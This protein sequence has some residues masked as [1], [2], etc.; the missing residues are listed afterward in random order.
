MG[1][2]AVLI[3]EQR[4]ECLLR[5]SFVIGRHWSCDLQLDHKRMPLRWIEIRWDGTSWRWRALS[6]ADET[7]G[8]G[9]VELGEWRRLGDGDADRAQIALGSAFRVHLLD[10]SPPSSHL[11]NVKTGEIIDAHLDDWLEWVDERPFA[12]GWDSEMEPEALQDGA[13]MVR[14]GQVWR[15]HLAIVSV[16]TE[17]GAFDLSRP[18]L[19]LDL[20]FNPIRATFTLGS[21]Q[22]ILEGNGARLVAAYA[23]VRRAS[24][25]SDP[26]FG[27][28]E[29]YAEWCA[30]GGTGDVAR[31]GW[32]RGKVRTRLRTAGATGCKQLFQRHFEGREVKMRL[33]IP[34]ENVCFEDED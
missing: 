23:Q 33:V 12:L 9:P 10:P 19:R 32:E 2:I 6:D 29:V 16:P 25:S 5:A 8:R 31:I 7:R 20:G 26:W 28:S 30:L 15:L 3:G 13:T 22:L 34:P 14:D 11:V 17:R 24:T 1:R 21:K 27:P 4:V 18:A